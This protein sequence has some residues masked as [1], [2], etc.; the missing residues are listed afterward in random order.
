M[1]RPS[2][3]VTTGQTSSRSTLS[4]QPSAISRAPNAAAER[5]GGRVAAAQPAQ[6]DDVPRPACRV[7]ASAQVVGERV[8]DGR[9]VGRVRARIVA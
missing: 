7:A 3:S 1:S 2:G 6:V 8:G 4:V 9:Q 5:V